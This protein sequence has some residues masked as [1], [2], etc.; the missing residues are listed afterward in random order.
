MDRAESMTIWRLDG[1]SPSKRMLLNAGPLSETAIT[2]VICPVCGQVRSSSSGRP[3]SWLA[4]LI[5]WSI[6]VQASV[7]ACVL[8]TRAPRQNFVT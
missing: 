1:P 5:A 7:T 8:E 2:G 6:A 3:S 4:A